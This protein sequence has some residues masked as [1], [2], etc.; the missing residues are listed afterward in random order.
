MLGTD[1]DTVKTEFIKQ[2]EIAVDQRSNIQL[3]ISRMGIVL[4]NEIF[5]RI[6]DHFL[7]ERNRQT[8]FLSFYS[9]IIGLLLNNAFS[10]PRG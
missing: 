2:Y 3:L 5:L 9:Q 10:V 6:P 8:I 4:R 7:W 1:H